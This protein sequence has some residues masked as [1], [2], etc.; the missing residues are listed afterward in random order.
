MY[1]LRDHCPVCGEELFASRFD[2]VFRMQDAS[3]RLAFA[4]PAALCTGCR[5]L[6]VEP[7]QIERHGLPD[8]RCIF[9]IESDVALRE[10]IV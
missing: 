8:G 5:Q 4:L 7:A 2:A 10:R 9:A 3:E 1:W 6:Y